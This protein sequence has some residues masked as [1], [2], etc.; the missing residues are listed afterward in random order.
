MKVG[1]LTF[2][3][4]FNPGAFLQALGTQ[5]LLEDLGHDPWVLNYTAPAHRYS[6]WRKAIALSYRLPFRMRYLCKMH[7]KWRAFAKDRHSLIRLTQYF[8]SREDLEREHFD[9]VLIG[10]D[11]VWNYELPNLGKDPVYFG[12]SIRT[13]KL[14]A[15]A[16]SVGNC[17]VEG[18]VPSYV[19][20]GLS[21]FHRISVRDPLTQR[22]VARVTGVKPGIICDPAFHLQPEAII[23]EGVEQDDYI[24]VYLMGRFCSSGLVEQ[25]K[26]YAK[27]YKLKIVATLYPNSWAD[28][29][30]ICHGPREW[31]TLIRRARYIVTNTF[32]GTVFAIMMKK[33][34]TVQYTPLIQ[35]K[36]E[37]M[38]RQLG[39]E[40]RVLTNDSNLPHILETSWDTSGVSQ[41]IEILKY[42]ARCFI[43]EALKGKDKV[44]P[45]NSLG[46]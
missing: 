32:H 9:A 12:Q 14:I 39:L 18:G 1:I 16:P 37:E 3:E 19:A 36:T 45:L 44:N 5:T 33:Q 43:Q 28:E 20:E 38:V 23:G 7:L 40:S 11:I 4:V 13:D 30:R 22:L 10:A 25:I 6:T 24:L 34:F 35:T 31:L 15:F 41:E 42:E 17:D 2:H 27:R 29:N 21:R 26:S 8:E 46:A